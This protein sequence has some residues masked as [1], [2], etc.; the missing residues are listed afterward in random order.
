MRRI[1]KPSLADFLLGALLYAC[2]ARGGWQALL[3]DGDTGW[4]IRTGELI[5]TT[6]RVPSADPFSFTR[7]GEPWFAWEW[8]S[9]VIFAMLHRHWGLAG[10][11]G[12]AAVVLALAAVLLFRRMLRAG[13][14]IWIALPL[15]L[16]AAGASSVHY[17]AR[18][19]VFTI[20]GA[21]AAFGILESERRLWLLVPMAALWTNLHGGWVALV[22]SVWLLAAVRRKHVPVAAACTA[23]TLL[24]PYGWRLHAHVFD[25]L[26]SGW[27]LQNVQEFQPPRFESEGL[28][29]FAALLALG[30]AMV[31]RYAAARRWYPALITLV[32]ALAALR[33]ARHVPVYAAAAAPLA[34]G[35]LGALWRGVRGGLAE[36]FRAIG[37]DFSA[38]GLR[39]SA[40]APVLAAGVFALSPPACGFPEQRFPVAA[41]ERLAPGARVLTSDQWGDYLIYRLYPR[42][43]VFFDG[44]SDFYGPALGRQYQS[45]MSA[46]GPWESVFERYA[47]QFALLP[48]DWP[49]QAVLARD[50]RWRLVYRDRT[51]ALFARR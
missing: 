22:A 28:L 24:N 2:F 42:Q 13:A 3:A 47:F 20:L 49:L 41:V 50:P 36:T 12:L 6:G 46:T 9:D 39:F 8:L 7:A 10:V 27:I 29:Q 48:H 5:L 40:W 26:R 37:R 11:A 4:H 14:D 25:Y 16:A 51:A 38:E 32:W 21:A 33:S 35:E 44:R 17:L 31:S 30:L 19:H 34:A 15:A 18:P 1:F 23:A 43:R 45:L